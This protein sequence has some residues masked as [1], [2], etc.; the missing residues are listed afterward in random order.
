MLVVASYASA[1]DLFEL[2]VFEYETVAPGDYEV[3]LHTNGMSRGTISPPT[4]A[5]NHRPV[6]LS[7]ELR[8]GWTNRLETAIF[9]QSAPFGPSR[10]T[11]FAG[12][13]LRGKVRLGQIPSTPLNVAV[14]AEYAFN[15]PAFDHELQTFEV[16]GI[17]S[18]EHGRF[19]ILANPSLEIVTHGSKEGLDPVFDVSAKVGV[20][21]ATH[22]SVA[23]DY[24]SAAATT[25]HLLPEPSAHHLMFGGVEF[26]LG[27]GW[28][29]DISAGHCVTSSEPWL[30]KSIVGYRF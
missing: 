13:H 8:R 14:G 2:E 12:G 21:V 30:M 23:L 18:F 17:V 24:F 20:R 11:A 10:S 15:R 9:V 1:Q 19:L 16:R 27:S 28:E 7:V 22:V 3:E 5:E 25:R 6:H 29:F 4:L 26:D